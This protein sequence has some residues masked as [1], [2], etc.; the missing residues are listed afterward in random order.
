MVGPGVV[1]GCGVEV[2]GWGVVDVGCKVNVVSRELEEPCVEVPCDK[3]EPML[4]VAILVA[5]VVA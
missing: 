5:S 4:D 2:V 3:V 1:V